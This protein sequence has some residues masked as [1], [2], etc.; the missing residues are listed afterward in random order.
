[1]AALPAAPEPPG[2]RKAIKVCT[3]ATQLKTMIVRVGVAYRLLT[4]LNQRGTSLNRLI[5]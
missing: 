2:V 4:L 1:M 5:E 3:I